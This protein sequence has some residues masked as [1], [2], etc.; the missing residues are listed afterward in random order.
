MFMV[1]S[2]VHRNNITVVAIA[3]SMSQCVGFAM[4]LGGDRMATGIGQRIDME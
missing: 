1:C 4:A 3:L 2:Y